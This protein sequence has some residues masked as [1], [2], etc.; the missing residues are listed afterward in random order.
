MHEAWVA[1]AQAQCEAAAVAFFFKQ[2]GGWGVD[3]VKRNKK[4][5]GRLF[6]GGAPGTITRP[7]LLAESLASRPNNAQPTSLNR[8]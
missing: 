5:N 8:P 3:G 7:F 6:R 4:A 2:W 1:S